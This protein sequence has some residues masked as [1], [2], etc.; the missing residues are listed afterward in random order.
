MQLSDVAQRVL[1]ALIEK[2][3]ATPQSYPLS[4]NALTAAAN[5]TT[6][7]DPVTDHNEQDIREGVKE[8]SGKA[9]VTAVYA[10]RSSTPK[11]A[12]HLGSYLEID[13]PAV[14]VLAVLLLRGPQTIGELR[15][16]CERLHPFAELDQV[17]DALQGLVGHVFGPLCQELPRQP[18]RKE[19]RWRHLLGG[20]SPAAEV[21]EAVTEGVPATERPHPVDD[22]RDEV[23]RLREQVTWLAAEVKRLS[24]FVGGDR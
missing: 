20:E 15:Q 6:N 14:A 5:Q 10:R 8:L 9:L 3:M 18:G 23:V 17:H 2:E 7:R 16:R 4:L 19:T 24:H 12:H 11:Y 22:L 1:G 21:A 13:Q